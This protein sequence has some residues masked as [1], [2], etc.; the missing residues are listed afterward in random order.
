MSE[1]LGV[2]TFRE[3]GSMK[4]LRLLALAAVAFACTA[5]TAQ[6][7]DAQKSAA[8]TAK[9]GS[10]TTTNAVVAS[11]NGQVS[12]TPA[13]PADGGCAAHAMSCGSATTVTA[14]NTGKASGCA[15]KGGTAT[16]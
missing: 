6:A 5:P 13:V 3:V 10:A 14:S 9:A 11:S 4:S 12:T 2:I 1:C 7:C 8:K 16:A 15:M